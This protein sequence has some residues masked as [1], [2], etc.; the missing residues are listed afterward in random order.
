MNKKSEI[1]M[2]LGLLHA[3]E[4]K[5]EKA[6]DFLLEAASLNKNDPRPYVYMAKIAAQKGD[7]SGAKK[8]Q[9]EADSRS[10]QPQK[11]TVA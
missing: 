1:P 4:G 8:Y 5:L 7:K 10:K 2:A 11:K 9:R 6:F 3:K